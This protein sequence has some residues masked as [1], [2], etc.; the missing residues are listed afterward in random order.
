MKHRILL[1]SLLIAATMAACTTIKEDRSSCPCW[2]TIDFSNVDTS[3]KS[4]HLWFFDE[5]G[6]LLYRDIINSAEY[7]NLYEIELKRGNVQYYVWGNVAENTMLDDNSTL[8]TS[9]LRLENVQ[10]DPLY[11]YGKRLN[12]V[13]ENCSDTIIMQ[14]EYSI[15]E[16]ELLGEPANDY[17]L[18]M[19]TEAGTAGRYVDGRFIEEKCCIEAQPYGVDSLPC[20][21]SFKIIRQKD[22]TGLKMKLYTIVDDE[23]IVLREFPLGSWLLGLG[24]DMKSLNLTDI[25]VQLDISM[26]M[27]SIKIEDW[28]MTYPVMIVL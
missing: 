15:V 17:P 8:N 4:L 11:Y 20:V 6:T 16:V 14:K 3:V 7:T 12:T 18:Y 22:L 1:C 5:A 9:L 26:G 13:G 27:A 21:F 24:Y 19:D 25:S 23:S 28:N 10:A 2:C